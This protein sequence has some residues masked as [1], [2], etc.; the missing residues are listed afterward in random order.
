MEGL[1][2]TDGTHFLV[3]DEGS[4]IGDVLI[5]LLKDRSLQ[6]RLAEAGRD[7]AERHYSWDVLGRRL[8]EK[9]VSLVDR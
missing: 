3:R 2:G 8:R 4:A 1:M 9:Y 7:M 5:E 6:A